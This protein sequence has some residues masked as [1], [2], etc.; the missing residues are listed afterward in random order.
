MSHSASTQAGPPIARI[1]C[2]L[3]TGRRTSCERRA[4]APAAAPKQHDCQ[5]EGNTHCHLTLP[6][7]VDAHCIHED[8]RPLLK[9]RVSVTMNRPGNRGV[10][11]QSGNRVTVRDASS[12]ARA[13]SRSTRGLSAAHAMKPALQGPQNAAPA[14]KSAHQGPKTLCLPQN[15]HINQDSQCAALPRRF[16]ARALPK[17]SRDNIKI[18]KGQDSLHLP[19]KAG[20]GPPKSKSTRFPLRLLRP[21]TTKSENARYQNESAVEESTR[22]QQ[23][24]R[25]CAVEMH[26]KDLEVNALNVR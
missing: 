25:T 22:A 7:D 26:F 18:T 20:F 11:G 16:A 8:M 4:T 14:R 24:R 15:L 3:P 5:K 21:V 12:A 19:R 13:K 23:I 2:R 9:Q 10:G 6:L 1:T 17:T